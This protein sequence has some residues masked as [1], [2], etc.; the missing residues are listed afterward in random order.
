MPLVSPNFS[1]FLNEN[2][3]WPFQKCDDIQPV[4]R[5]GCQ[6]T[7]LKD[8]RIGFANGFPCGPGHLW[9]HTT[10]A[11]LPKVTCIFCFHQSVLFWLMGTH[12]M[13]FFPP[14]NST[15]DITSRTSVVWLLLL[16]SHTLR[17]IC[18]G[19]RKIAMM[20]GPRRSQ[21]RKWMT[22]T[23]A[24]NFLSAENQLSSRKLCFGYHVCDAQ[25]LSPSCHVCIPYAH[26]HS[27]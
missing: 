4:I 14:E 21:L 16:L 17:I 26:L 10:F 7:C 13:L 2:D 3:W 11:G 23:W 6:E 25:F 22:G 27:V 5:S 20:S 8:H 18:G 24:Y 12:L 9:L 15:S 19:L 1:S